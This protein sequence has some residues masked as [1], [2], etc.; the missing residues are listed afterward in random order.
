MKFGLPSL[1]RKIAKNTISETLLTLGIAVLA[2]CAALTAFSA[3]R[4][5]R[6][7]RLKPPPEECETIKTLT[8]RFERDMEEILRRWK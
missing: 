3:W 7:R 2:F 6:L 1:G 8:D 4:I 5:W